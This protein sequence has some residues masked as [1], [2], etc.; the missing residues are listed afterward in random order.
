MRTR[1]DDERRRRRLEEWDE[2]RDEAME[3]PVTTI[4]VGVCVLIATLIWWCSRG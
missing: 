1:G 4:L 2:E 3:A